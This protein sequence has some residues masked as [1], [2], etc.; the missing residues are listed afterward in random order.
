MSRSSRPSGSGP[1]PSAEIVV[2]ADSG[3]WP[4]VDNPDRVE[5]LVVGF[6]RRI[7]G[8]PARAAE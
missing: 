3:H 1:F 6:L 7:V 4:F 5:D 8:S 2:M